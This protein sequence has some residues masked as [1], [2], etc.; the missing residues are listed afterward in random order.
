MFH[1]TDIYVPLDRH[2]CLDGA[3]LGFVGRSAERPQSASLGG[4]RAWPGEETQMVAALLFP[5]NAC[6]TIQCTPAAPPLCTCNQLA[7]THEHMS[8]HCDS[9][10]WIVWGIQGWRPDS[11]ERRRHVRSDRQGVATSPPSPPPPSATIPRI[12]FSK[13]ASDPQPMCVWGAGG[14][15][16]RD[17][18]SAARGRDHRSPGRRSQRP[19][20]GQLLRFYACTPIR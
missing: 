4:P 15:S 6:P 10:A 3:C 9:C 16:F 7:F 5:S 20:G 8:T 17:G 14:V 11:G 12:L 19:P 18:G 2:F 1:S 13:T